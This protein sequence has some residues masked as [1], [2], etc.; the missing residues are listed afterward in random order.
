MLFL[1]VYFYSTTKQW[2]T[3]QL[4]N[5]FMSSSIHCIRYYFVLKIFCS[6]IFYF[7]INFTIKW[8]LY[9]IF[10]IVWYYNN[11]T[12]YRRRHSKLLYQLSCFVGHPVLQISNHNL[13]CSLDPLNQGRL[14][15]VVGPVND[16]EYNWIIGSFIKYTYVSEMTGR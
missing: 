9:N 1:V 6:N 13:L 16:N 5:S 3:G 10:I 14:F 8:L 2:E 4:V 15:W 7:E 11:L 12:N